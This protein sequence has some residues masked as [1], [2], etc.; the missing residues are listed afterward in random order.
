MNRE[1]IGKILKS[2]RPDGVSNYAI[3]KATGLKASQIKSLES[4]SDNYTIDSLLAY[5]EY[6]NLALIPTYY[7]TVVFQEIWDK[8][9]KPINFKYNLDGT[10]IKDNNEK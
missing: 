3:C 10:L 9:I 7:K 4:G 8:Y 6:L 2:N 5:C 1:D